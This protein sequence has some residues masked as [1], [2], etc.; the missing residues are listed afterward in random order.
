MKRINLF[1]GC[2]IIL[3][4]LLSCTS[5]ADPVDSAALNNKETGSPV[6]KISRGSNVMYLGGS[7]HTL[8]DTDFPL[9][10]E[11]DY[12]FSMS[13]VL[14]LETDINKMNS[15]EVQEYL[16]FNS[17]FLDGR[18]L[19]TVLS[20]QTFE[21]LSQ[22]CAEY[23]FPIVDEIELFKP[24][25]VINILTVL[26]IQELGFA[27]EG[28]DQYYF[29]KAVR[30]NKPVS[31]LETLQSQIDVM[32]S[33]GEGYEDEYVLYSLQDIDDTEADLDIMVAEWKK[34]ITATAEESLTEMINEWPMLYKSM[35]TDR[36]DVW[37]PQIDEF[38][39]SGKTHFVIVGFLHLPGPY[40]LLK[41]LENSGCTVEQL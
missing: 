12:A 17:L 27:E 5:S 3:A 33:M 10:D 19:K 40:G 15:Q 26:M 14:V 21:I 8:R 11:F 7:I 30:E 18:S 24:S 1:F 13:D 23:G 35:I 31:F 25:M 4:G 37:F 22:V 32:V 38:L 16:I 36:H 29:E 41:Y 20:P 28:V 6:W 2:F 34:G 39:V 9:P